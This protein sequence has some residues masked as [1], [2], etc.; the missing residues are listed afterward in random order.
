MALSTV[1]ISQ[2]MEWAK[3]LSFNRL[4]AIGN[5]LEPALTSAN[6]IMQTILGPPFSW[7]WNNQE[8]TFSCN[9]VPAVSSAISNV[10]VTAGVVTLT[11]ANTFAAGNL[12]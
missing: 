3:K 2:T 4:S 7:W 12:V 10:A 8:L 1:T 9:T 5:N 11:V 6:M